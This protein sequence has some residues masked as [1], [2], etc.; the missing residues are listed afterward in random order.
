MTIEP[1][2]RD[3]TTLVY[4]G[5]CRELVPELGIRADA[6]VTDPPYGETAHTWDQWPPGWPRILSAAA[7]S[8]WCFGS[9]RL[10]HA[11]GSEFLPWEPSHDVV[12]RKPNATGQRSDRF[13][14]T[15][16][17]AVHWYHGSWDEVYHQP[18]RVSGQV[19]SR[20]VLNRG[21]NDSEWFGQRKGGTWSDDG[22]RAPVSVIDSPNMWKRNPLHPTEKPLRVL[23]PL[24]EFAVPPDGMVLDP[25]AGSGST[26]EAARQCGRRAVLIERSERYCEVIATRMSQQFID[27]PGATAAVLEEERR[28]AAAPAMHVTVQPLF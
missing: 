21:H 15:H 24:V 26:G 8:M 10:F 9:F 1:Y 19:S 12:W 20:Q 7:T 13:R 27:L 5:D 3:A 25:F 6:I 17:L 23:V 2:Y 18:A 16:E 28:R 4:L 22:S 14:R 11:K